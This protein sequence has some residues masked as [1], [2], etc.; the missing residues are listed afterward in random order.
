MPRDNQR[1]RTRKDLL[2][3]A[4]RL[5]ASG[6][7]PTLD[8]VAEEALVSRATA[9]RY[10]KNADEL[11][12]EASLHMAFP[13]PA[14]MLDLLEED[15]VARLKR[16]DDEVAAMILANEPSLRLFLANSIQQAANGDGLPARQNR[17]TPLIEAALAPAAESFD[18]ASFERLKAALGLIIGTEA[19]IVFKDV[20]QLSDEEARDVRHW[21]IESLVEA[22]QRKAER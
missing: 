9:Y 5:S 12:L 17:R 19:T 7:K 2:E 21:A 16:A 1:N 11:L 15:P 10:F 6:D 13:D 4:L 3:A 14:A 8:Q 18:P 22:A 20:L